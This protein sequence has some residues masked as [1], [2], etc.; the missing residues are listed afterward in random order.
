MTNHDYYYW[1]MIGLVF[2]VPVDLLISHFRMELSY[3]WFF[4]F[5]IICVAMAQKNMYSN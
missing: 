2:Y 3:L 1:E 5:V 4:W